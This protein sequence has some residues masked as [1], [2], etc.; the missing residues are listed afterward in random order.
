MRD[1]YHSE[2]WES[3]TD[4]RTR[5]AQVTHDLNNPLTVIAGN[6]QLLAELIRA[7]NLP[8]DLQKPVRDIEEASLQLAGSLHALNALSESDVAREKTGPVARAA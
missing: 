8:E 7:F 4:L 6:A 5:V 2:P 1:S 3:L